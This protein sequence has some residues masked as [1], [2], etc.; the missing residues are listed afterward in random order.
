MFVFSKSYSSLSLWICSDISLH[1]VGHTVDILSNTNPSDHKAKFFSSYK[2]HHL[3]STFPKFETFSEFD[4]VQLIRIHIGFSLLWLYG[5]RG[6]RSVE[7]G[8]W[9]MKSVGMSIAENKDCGKRKCEKWEVG[10]RGL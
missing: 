4:D 1:T 7:C 9:K 8:V 10:K 3:K 5:K 2:V 6:V